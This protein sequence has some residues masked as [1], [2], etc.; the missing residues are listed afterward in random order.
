MLIHLKLSG[1]F[2]ITMAELSETNPWP[3]KPQIFN[4]LEGKNRLQEFSPTPFDTQS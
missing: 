1:C 4:V 2:L 3:A